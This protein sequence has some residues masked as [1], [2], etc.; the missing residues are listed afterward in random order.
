MQSLHKISLQMT[1]CVC[2]LCPFLIDKI[3]EDLKK[4]N[5][6]RAILTEPHCLKDYKPQKHKQPQPSQQLGTSHKQHC[7]SIKIMAL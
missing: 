6:Y 4:A 7:G 3:S 2:W 5:F 1:E